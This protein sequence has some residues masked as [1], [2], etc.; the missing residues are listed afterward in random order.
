MLRK[1]AL[2]CFMIDMKKRGKISILF[3]LLCASSICY[4]Q[5][6]NVSDSIFHVIIENPKTKLATRKFSDGIKK[7]FHELN[8]LRNEWTAFREFNPKRKLKEEGV[9]LNGYNYGIWTRYDAKGNI[10][11]QI[12]YAIP[13]LI[14]GEQQTHINAFDEVKEIGDSII[15]AHFDA[16]FAKSIRLNASR[17]YWYTDHSSGSWF[18]KSIGKPKRYILRYSIVVDDT[19]FFTPIEIQISR[20]K[21]TALN[22]VPT[23]HASQFKIDYQEAL[24]I[25]KAKGYGQIHNTVFKDNEFMQLVFMDDTYYWCISSIKADK[26]QSYPQSNSLRITADGQRL[27]INAFTGDIS[28]EDFEGV[29]HVCE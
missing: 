3:I 5:N 29:M 19:L 6:R 9:Y 23:V 20:Q 8:N 18:E 22:G 13:K 7:E 24:E 26:V 17:T 11:S 15:T 27:Y 2:L 4:G 14:I 1:E 25:A 12:D 21:V 28:V 10:V 16:D